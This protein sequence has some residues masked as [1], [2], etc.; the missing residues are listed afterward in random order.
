MIH[1]LQG[2]P[3]LVEAQAICPT[4]EPH[5][6]KVLPCRYPCHAW[7]V[8][9]VCLTNF[10]WH[11]TSNPKCHM[12]FSNMKLSVNWYLHFLLKCHLNVTCLVI[13]VISIWKVSI[14]VWFFL[15]KSYYMSKIWIVRVNWHAF[16]FCASFCVSNIKNLQKLCQKYTRL[17]TRV[18]PPPF[19]SPRAYFHNF[20]YCACISASSSSSSSSSVCCVCVCVSVSAFCNLS[21]S[22]VPS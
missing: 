17:G 9:C 8:Q 21:G 5:L 15:H 20:S 22:C 19:A 10:I 3:R 13:H 4:L 16:Y 14:D 2:L 18:K 12:T 7:E 6:G 11:W 1:I